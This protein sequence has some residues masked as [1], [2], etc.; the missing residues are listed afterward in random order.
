MST[1]YHQVVGANS[2]AP[3]TLKV[4]RGEGVA[5][6]GMKGRDESPRRDFVG[7]A[8]ECREL[9]GDRFHQCFHGAQTYKTLRAMLA[10][11][12]RAHWRVATA[13]ARGEGM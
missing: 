2:D 13:T 8:F 6:V 5:L 3:F 11:T 9:D 10:A 7:V 4:H 12:S 1:S